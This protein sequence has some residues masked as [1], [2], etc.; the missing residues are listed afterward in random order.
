MPPPRPISGQTSNVSI[1][2]GPP[3]PS[4]IFGGGKESIKKYQKPKENLDDY[5]EDEEDLHQS[6][7]SSV[8]KVPDYHYPPI[9]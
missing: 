9:P 2:G 3:K 4:S 5:T 6:K 8:S 7:K 1:L